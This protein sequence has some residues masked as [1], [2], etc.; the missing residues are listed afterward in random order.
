MIKTLDRYIIGTILRGVGLV[1][2]IVLVL[3]G[4]FLFMEQQD[5]I[6]VGRYTTADALL[7]VLLN[8][9]QQV[10]ELLPITA[11]IGALLALGNLARG[12]EL[13]VLRTAGLSPW[14]LARAVMLSGVLLMLFGFAMTE[15]V[16]P[17]AV[18]LARQAKAFAKFS[19]VDLGGSHESWARDGNVILTVERQTGKTQFG[20]MMLFE[21]GPD[22]ALRSIGRAVTARADGTGRW[23]LEPF[24]ESRFEGDGVEAVR[25]PSR[26]ITSKIGAEFLGI[27]A[28]EPSQLS[29]LTLWRVIS[30][31]QDNGLDARE[32]RYVMWSRLAR[33]VAAFF[34]VLLAFPFVF[35]SLRSASTGSWIGT[36]LV[37][38]LAFFMLQ[39]LLE[40]SVRVFGYSP[41]LFAWIPPALMAV[42]ALTLIARLR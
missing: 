1:G 7:F 14:R 30:H 3:G 34:S 11:L 4:L 5:D 25:A 27:A 33:I 41:L 16:A 2:A 24:A 23:S 12:S 32:S 21:L 42:V 19:N 37:L 36:G 31:L 29:T 38:G 35:G 9:P 8:L 40:S 28:S 22:N 20:G 13:T 10:W 18:Q 39:N 17:P 26:V 15:I 6:G